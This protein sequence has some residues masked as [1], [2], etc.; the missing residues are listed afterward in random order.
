MKTI[1]KEERRIK[2]MNI[3]KS[4]EYTNEDEN[5]ENTHKFEDI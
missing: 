4:Y 2:M 1:N 3:L 5:N